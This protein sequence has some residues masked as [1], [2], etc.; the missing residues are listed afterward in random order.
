MIWVDDSDLE[1]RKEKNKYA[2]ISDENINGEIRYRDWD[3]L[4]YWFRAVEKF[5]PWVNNVYFITCGHYPKWLNLK[6]DKL[7]FIKH[8]EY[9]PKEYLPTFSSHAIELNFHRIKGLS[10]KFVYFNDD[11]F[12]TSNVEKE[13]F[14]EKDLP[15]YT[16]KHEAFI[17]DSNTLFFQHIL[18][19]NIAIIN[20]YF[21]K[22]EV[23]KKNLLK[24]FSLKNQLKDN[25]KNLLLLPYNKFSLITDLHMPSP[26]LKSTMKEV[27]EKEYEVLNKTSSDKFRGMDGVNQYLFKCYD[28][29]RGKFQVVDSKR[30][31]YYDIEDENKMLINDIRTKI[32]KFICI[33]DSNPNVDFEKAKKEIINAFEEILPEKSS[34]EI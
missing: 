26:L 14:F 16:L 27:W 15:K 13:D 9:I 4:K 24:W 7:K 28:I 8:D 11:M 33:N 34:F 20:K 32:Y 31:K 17:P 2:G 25:L 10:E 1:W 3:N 12:L 22:K 30:L 18:F 5:A 19:N 21:N 23:M 29:A 6:C